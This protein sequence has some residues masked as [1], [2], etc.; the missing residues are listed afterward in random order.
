MSSFASLR[1]TAAKLRL[2]RMTRKRL[3]F[4]VLEKMVS[5]R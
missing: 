4:N 3:I 1:M 5:G 2:L